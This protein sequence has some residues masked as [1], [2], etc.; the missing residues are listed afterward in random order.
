M[1]VTPALTDHIAPNSVQQLE[2][3]AENRFKEGECLKRQNRLLA[4]LYLYGYSVEMCLAAA[5]FEV[6]PCVVEIENGGS[7]GP[8]GVARTTFDQKRRN[9]HEKRVHEVLG[10]LENG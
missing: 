7:S 6:V 9:R 8:G 2:R 5:Y 3:A 4:A 1:A 10:V